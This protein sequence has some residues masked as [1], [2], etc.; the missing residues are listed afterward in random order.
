[1]PSSQL[2][3]YLHTCRKAAG[4]SQDEVAFLL[5]SKS[6]A[7]VCRYERFQQNPNLESLLA[8]EIL[9]QTPVR[10]LFRGVHQEV[11]RNLLKRIRALIRRLTKT[12]ND[13]V[14]AHKISVLRTLSQRGPA[15]LDPSLD[16]SS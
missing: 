3:N 11:E 6:G 13:R 7:R 16:Y 5:G 10:I 14:N 9:F 4:L 1:M 12:G 15:P 2:P 8:Y